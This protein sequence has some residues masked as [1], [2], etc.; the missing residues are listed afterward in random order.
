MFAPKLRTH[1]TTVCCF[2]INRSNDLARRETNLTPSL[3]S[4]FANQ[5]E[6]FARG[7]AILQQGVA[8]RA[9]PCAT[10]AV[11]HRGKLLALKAFG[12]FTYDTDAPV[13]CPDTIFDL[14]SITKVMA[15]TSMAVLLYQRGLLD[16]EMPVFGILPEFAED[17]SVPTDLP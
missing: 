2:A 16:I 14:A 12:R 5:D 13:A 4:D 15:T 9:F 8:D 3:T 1:F 10:V 17:S 6:V 11:T 7:C